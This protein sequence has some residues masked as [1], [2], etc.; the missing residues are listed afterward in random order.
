[1]MFQINDV[2]LSRSSQ[3]LVEFV[4]RH[5]FRHTRMK[6]IVYS[7]LALFY[8]INIVVNVLN[9]GFIYLSLRQFRKRDHDIE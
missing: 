4:S 9:D 1:M 2:P 7:P 3:S 8:K 5:P 6:H